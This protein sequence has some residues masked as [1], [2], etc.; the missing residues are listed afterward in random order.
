MPLTL[1]LWATYFLR[2]I[3]ILLQ[4]RSHATTGIEVCQIGIHD[5]LEQHTRVIAR[6]AASFVGGFD[7]AD[8]EVV[9]DWVFVFALQ[10]YRLI[11]TKVIAIPLITKRIAIIF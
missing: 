11:H 7:F 9:K 8:V 6:C 2:F 3:C 1:V 10:I 5:Y 4:Q